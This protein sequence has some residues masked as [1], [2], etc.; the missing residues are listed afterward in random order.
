MRVVA[1]GSPIYAH[2]VNATPFLAGLAARGVEVHQAVATPL[3]DVVPAGVGAWDTGPAPDF[4]PGGG[5]RVAEVGRRYSWLVDDASTRVGAVREVLERLTPDLVL[6]DSLGY[7][8]ALAAEQVGLPWVSFGDGPL[9]FPDRRT[10]PFGA[11]LP[12][13]TPAPWV[14]RNVVVQA[15]S[16]H[17]VMAAPQRRY[18]ELRASLGLP[19]RDLP[20]LE[21]CLSPH[22]HLHCGVPE[23]EYPRER[24]PDHVRFVGALRPPEPPG[25]AAPS[26]WERVVE[27]HPGQVVLVT[28]GTLRDDSAEVLRPAL[29]LLLETGRAGVLTTGAAD[30]A[31]LTAS[32]PDLGAGGGSVAV[33]SFVPYGRVLPHAGAF[34]TN[35]GWTGVLLAL[36]HGVPVVQVGR[37]EEKAD[38]GRRVEWAGAGLHVPAP[39][40]DGRALRRALDAVLAEPAYR[41]GAQRLAGALARHDPPREGAELMLRLRA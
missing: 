15:A 8:A 21:A 34:V 20:V 18:A 12:Y 19:A 27:Q 32:A 23:L 1:A 14:W 30:P 9:H 31:S 25:W 6:T 26:W 5:G 39:G 37:T 41:E 13:R 33:E 10:P 3:L 29:H 11:G 7:A 17:V 22:L 16:R 35:G 24:L 28:Q 40:R 4:G 38:I 36:A 2:T